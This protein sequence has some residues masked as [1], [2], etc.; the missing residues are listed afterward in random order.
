MAYH[1]DKRNAFTTTGN[2][3]SKIA[4]AKIYQVDKQKETI[5]HDE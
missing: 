5:V 3:P 4:K 2:S 1:R